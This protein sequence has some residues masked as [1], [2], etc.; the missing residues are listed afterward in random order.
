MPCLCIK[1]TLLWHINTI[2]TYRPWACINLDWNILTLLRD[3]SIDTVFI[4]KTA[5]VTMLAVNNCY[6]QNKQKRP[7]SKT[8]HHAVSNHII[9]HLYYYYTNTNYSDQTEM[10]RR[11]K[12][13]YYSSLLNLLFLKIKVY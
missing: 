12:E 7:C 10:K 6:E 1:C 5:S 9:T 8:N 2:L 4:N 3:S 13:T 11:K